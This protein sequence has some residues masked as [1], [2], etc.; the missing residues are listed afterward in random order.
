M[1][2]QS[3]MIEVSQYDRGDQLDEWFQILLEK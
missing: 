2:K 1:I 3:D